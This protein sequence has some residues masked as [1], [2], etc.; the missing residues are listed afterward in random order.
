[1]SRSEASPDAETASYW[2]VFI[3]L[4]ISSEVPATLVLTLHP[5]CF[6]NGCTQSTFLSLEPSSAYPA[7]ATR[8][9]CPS[10]APSDC[11]AGILGTV[12]PPWPGAVALVEAA[13]PPPQAAA[14]RPVRAAAA[15]ASARR[16]D[17][18]AFSLSRGSYGWEACGSEAYGWE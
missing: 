16:L 2:P 6:S 4:P 3:R 14:T 17:H 1:M 10:P 12:K 13:S 9:T 11:S 7:Q 15:V 5:V 8:L 18:M